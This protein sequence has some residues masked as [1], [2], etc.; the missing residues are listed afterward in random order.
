MRPGPGAPRGVPQGCL[1]SDLLA[2]IFLYEFDRDMASQQYHY[3]RYVDDIRVLGRTKESVQRALIRV[4][5]QLKFFGILLQAKK[6][7]VRQITDI[8]AEVDRL[9]AQLSEID[10]RLKEPSPTQFMTG[11]PILKA[12]LR[13]VALMGDDLDTLTDDSPST[14]QDDLRTLFWKSKKSIDSD[15]GDLFAERHLRFCL[16]RLQPDEEIVDAVLPYFVDKPWLSEAITWYLKKCQLF[17][18]STNQLKAIIE[19]HDVYDSVVALAIEVLIKQ[20]TSLR[21]YHDTFK[22]WLIDGKKEWPLLCNTAI[23]LGEASDNMSVL[24]QAR[25]LPSSAV[26]R[27]AVIQALRIARTHEE[28]SHICRL[29][30]DDSS[31]V[32]I[33]TLLYLMYSEYSLTL[34]DINT[35]HQGVSDYCVSCAKGYDDSLPAIQPDYIRHVFVRSY[36]VTTQSTV[37]FHSLLGSDYDRAAQFL[38]RAEKSYLVNSSRYVA[39]L[40]LFHEELLYPILVDKLRLKATR[41]DLAQIELSN[42]IEMLQ[43]Q[44]KELASFAGALIDCRRLRANPEIHTRLHRELTET[45]SVTWQ[46]RNVLKKKLGAGYQELIDWLAAESP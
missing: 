24:L 41:Q 18:V 11:D 37:G 33:D 38:W 30:I 27:M 9:A 42:R 39:Q 12:P 22:K 43:K 44:K 3:L 8:Y 26:R 15:D 13:D 6:T 10:R 35:N 32:V 34:A 21:A 17:E 5:T 19:T 2:N 45:R 23:A 25:S 31:P 14:P 4:D 20:Q 28:A 7:T 40:D 1:A 29:A 46:Q 16:Y 36:G